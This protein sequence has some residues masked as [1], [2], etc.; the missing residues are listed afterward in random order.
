MP[1]IA[2]PNSAAAQVVSLPAYTSPVTASSSESEVAS[3]ASVDS[4][5]SSPTFR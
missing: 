2:K 4:T 3:G 5:A 1:G